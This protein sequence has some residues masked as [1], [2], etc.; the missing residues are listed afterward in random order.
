MQ[1]NTSLDYSNSP[2]KDA[3]NLAEQG[4]LEVIELMGAA[5]RLK[6]AGLKD[7]TISLYQLWLEHTTSPLKY[8]GYFNLGV[9]LSSGRDYLQS[10]AMYRNAL[11]LSPDF[12]RARLNMGNCLEQQKR[13]DE[14]LEQWRISLTS[15]SILLPENMPLLLHAYNNLGRLLEI[16]KN[17]QESLVML[18]KSF[19]LDPT[20]RDVLLH[21]VHLIQKICR[22][23]I[24]VPPKGITKQD[25]I[26]GTSPLAM[27]AASDDPKL[28][29]AAGQKFVEHKYPVTSSERLAPQCGYKHEK[30]RIGYLSSDF[31]P[32]SYTHLTLPTKRIV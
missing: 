5:D 1:D 12:V 20:Q 10:E 16:K 19:S 29:L 2:E 22:W 3:F 7:Q 32:V 24:Y 27:L 14:A 13:D 31:C 18:E 25:M 15:V 8:V 9:E 11:E 17:Y 23:P 21:L 30:I 26:D 6:S 4:T 28:Q